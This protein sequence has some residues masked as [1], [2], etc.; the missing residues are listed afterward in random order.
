MGDTS[1]RELKAGI[2]LLVCS[3]LILFFHAYSYN[4]VVDDAYISYRYA[5]NLVDGHGLV[6]NPGERVEG[7][8]NFL[9]VMIT[10]LG[11]QA[12]I[13]PVL[14]T[15][16]LC[17]AFSAL[18][19]VVLY[20]YAGPVFGLKGPL[21][22]LPPLLAAAS[23]AMAVWSLGGLETTFFA[24]LVTLAVLSHLSGVQRGRVPMASSA[25][26]LIASLTRPEGI[27]IAAILFVDLLWRRPGARA[28]WLWLIP[29]AAG[30][31]PYFVWRYSY[32]GF[33]FPNTFYA[34]TGGGLYHAA[35]GLSYAKGYFISPG[36]WLFMLA[37]VP[38]I[39]CRRKWGLV[40]AICAA[41]IAY[42]VAVGGDGLAMHRFFVPVIPLLFLLAAGG[43]REVSRRLA[44]SLGPRASAGLIAVIS[45][46]GLLTT[47]YPSM[48]SA[49]RDFVIEDRIRVQGNWVP[50]GKWLRD[51]ARPGDSI[52]VTAA[53]AL[54]YYSGLY[55]IDMLGIN[56]VHIA[57]R[58]MPA[59]GGGIAGHEKHDMEYVL[60][61]RP[62]YIFHYPFF[63][64][65][66]VITRDQFVTEWNPGMI[67]LFESEDFRRNYEPVSER[68]GEAVLNFFRLRA[69]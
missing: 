22:A 44:G 69:G 42:V 10:A 18:T 23:P 53:G 28:L 21:R 60:L 52:A 7:Y 33:L 13:A 19:L 63:T 55:T 9:W 2:L 26:A 12:G 65:R 4:Y 17:F 25:C 11:M 30:Y 59:G 45:A 51:Y 3:V 15:K 68:F 14:L 62:T 61:K 8:T 16:T 32:Y 38:L 50:I 24:F 34:K 46:L 54:P 49:D 6:F 35:R 64:G 39:A 57:H 36:G 27:L 29:L 67:L 43:A 58:D 31:I 20:R 1:G 48:S 66:P 5:R 56:D 37:I 47:L 40:L 41:W